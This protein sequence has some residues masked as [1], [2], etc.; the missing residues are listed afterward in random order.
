MITVLLECLSQD[1]HFDFR[2]WSLLNV[3]ME[4]NQE[5]KFEI[6]VSTVM[7]VSG[8]TLLVDVINT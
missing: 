4:G 6:K 7:I 2:I 3:N 8:S 5:N 1:V